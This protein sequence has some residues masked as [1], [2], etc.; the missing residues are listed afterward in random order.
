MGSRDLQVVCFSTPTPPDMKNLVPCE[1]S[2]S[3][4]KGMCMWGSLGY[5]RVVLCLCSFYFFIHQCSLLGQSHPS[6]LHS[7]STPLCTVYLGKCG[8]VNQQ[9]TFLLQSR[10]KTYTA[11]TSSSPSTMTLGSWSQALSG[12]NISSDEEL[13]GHYQAHH[14][15]MGSCYEYAN[16]RCTVADHF[17]L[18][19]SP[20]QQGRQSHSSSHRFLACYRS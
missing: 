10:V 2:P 13:Y 18:Q 16:R 14:K 3:M 6:L 17:G 12:L 4:I 7:H 9:P 8:G 11:R 20:V 19:K 15:V 1:C 5:S